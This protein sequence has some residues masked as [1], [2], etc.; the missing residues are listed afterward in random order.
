MS[1]DLKL[2]AVHDLAV[3]GTNVVLVDG[4]SRVRQQVKV[5]LMTRFG[6]YFLDVT[7]GVPYLE[8]ILVKR[9]NR[10]EIEAVLRQRINDVPGVTGVTRM[11]LNIDRERRQLEVSFQANTDEGLIA[12]TIT[13]E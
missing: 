10:S 9:P 11:Q 7:F 6:E 4:A 5:T 13:L 12:D 8:S 3:D 2:N 1:L